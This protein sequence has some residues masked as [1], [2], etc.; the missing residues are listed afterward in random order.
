MKRFN[1][2]FHPAFGWTIY[3]QPEAYHPVCLIFQS[4]DTTQLNERTATTAVLFHFDG[5]AD[6]AGSF[7][8]R[9]GQIQNTV[10][11][12]STDFFGVHTVIQCK[13]AAE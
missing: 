8:F 10:F 11:V 6:T 3:F 12:F 1:N 5:F 7:F 4:T 2:F 13:P 9:K